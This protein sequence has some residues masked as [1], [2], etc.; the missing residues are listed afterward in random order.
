MR[1]LRIVA[2]TSS[3]LHGHAIDGHD[4]V[5]AA[6][7]LRLVALGLGDAHE[8]VKVQAAIALESRHVGPKKAGARSR[9]SRRLGPRRRHRSFGTGGATT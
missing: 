6:V 7:L 4:N 5:E 9:I 2:V 8:V 1:L 3:D